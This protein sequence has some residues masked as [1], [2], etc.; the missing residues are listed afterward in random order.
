[1]VIKC[2]FQVSY[3]QWCNKVKENGSMFGIVKTSHR[4]KLGDVQKMSYQMVNALDL[5]T[6]PDVLKTTEDY[7]MSLKL[8]DD[9]F[10]DY[11]E[12]NKNFSNDYEVLIELC[13]QNPLF[14]RSS[15]FRE[16]KTIII[17][18]Y[19]LGV[20]SGKVIQNADNLTIVGS[21]YAMLMYTVGLNPEDDPTFDHE[22]GTIQCYTG[23]FND[24]EY[25]AGFRS[26]MNGMQNIAYLHN[27]YHEY[28]KKYFDL[29]NQIIAT[30]MTRTDFQDRCNGS[31]Q[32]LLD[33][34]V[35]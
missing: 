17:A 9:A 6:M 27:H 8:D 1:M 19:F 22:D 16:R 11:L 2:K 13:K 12:K 10:L 32:D 25:L 30:N 28:F 31:D 5:S 21:P 33:I 34:W 24:G 23:R 7:I 18:N 26:P 20:K 29:G 3:E 14:V 35:C 4:S 15:Y